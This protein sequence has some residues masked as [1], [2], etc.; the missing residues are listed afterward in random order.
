MEL[1]TSRSAPAGTAS[2]A[3]SAMART[4]V[5]C[6][7]SASRPPTVAANSSAVPVCE[8]HRTTTWRAR[9]GA[10]EES[11]PAPAC[12]PATSAGTACAG[13]AGPGTAAE[14]E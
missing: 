3:Q 14:R 5:G 2:G 7:A 11:A 12:A 10:A 13:T 8:A 1:I 9:E 4:V 6:P